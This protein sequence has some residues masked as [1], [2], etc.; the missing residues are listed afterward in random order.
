MPCSIR[1][2]GRGRIIK[3]LQ[4]DAKLR[5]YKKNYARAYRAK[6]KELTGFTQKQYQ[7]RE[8]VNKLQREYYYRTTAIDN[9][10]YL[11]SFN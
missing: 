3:L 7:K 11:F 8:I 9:I 10:R 2:E 4:N 5:E 6:Q 1:T